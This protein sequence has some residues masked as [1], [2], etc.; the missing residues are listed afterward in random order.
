MNEDHPLYGKRDSEITDEELMHLSEE[1]YG[2]YINWRLQ[3]N[4][5][6]LED[7]GFVISS[8]DPNTGEKIY[9][10]ASLDKWPERIKYK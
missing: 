1:E 10:N 6:Y 2:Q 5:K 8:L 3:I 7:E 4:M 9:L